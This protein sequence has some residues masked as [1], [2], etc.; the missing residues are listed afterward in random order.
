MAD[1]CSVV[2]LY[3]YH[4][5]G[6]YLK[7]YGKLWRDTDG[8]L[9]RMCYD[10]SDS[11]Y[12]CCTEHVTIFSTCQI[13]VNVLNIS[14]PVGILQGACSTLQEDAKCIYS[15]CRLTHGFSRLLLPQ[16][17]GTN[18]RHSMTGAS[19]T[20]EKLRVGIEAFGITT[21]GYPSPPTYFSQPYVSHFRV[22]CLY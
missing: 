22:F 8:K 12:G 17:I 19:A 21:S 7:I 9:N 4:N 13:M 15:S 1:G 2:H 20:N 16:T 5:H 14:K 10:H 18:N 6:M 11:L 3:H